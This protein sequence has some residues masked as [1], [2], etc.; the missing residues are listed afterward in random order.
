MAKLNPIIGRPVPAGPVAGGLPAFGGQHPRKTGTDR[1]NHGSKKGY[2]GSVGGLG[3]APASAGGGAF[4]S[5]PQGPRAFGGSVR[6][7]NRSAPAEVRHPSLM[8]RIGS[9]LRR[10]AAAFGS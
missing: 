8:N 9:R 10:T 5:G 4:R 2:T 6:L 3:R 1:V 7:P